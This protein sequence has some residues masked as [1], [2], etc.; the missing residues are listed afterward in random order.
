M[1][2][3]SNDGSCV[4]TK[5]LDTRMRWRAEP[6]NSLC[7]FKKRIA[8]ALAFDEL[9]GREVDLVTVEHLDFEGTVA[10]VDES[11]GLRVF[12]STEALKL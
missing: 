5:G 1:C 12:L 4:A 10:G 2:R 6:T 9:R 8:T 7:C 3:N 11:R